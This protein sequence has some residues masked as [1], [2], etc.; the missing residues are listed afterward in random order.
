VPQ[1]I[2]DRSKKEAKRL[3]KEIRSGG[4]PCPDG[5][6]AASIK[7]MQ[8]Q[9]VIAQDLGYRDWDDLLQRNRAKETV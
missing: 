9:H 3:L 1:Y 5:F 7:L 2:I 8:V 4:E 6:A